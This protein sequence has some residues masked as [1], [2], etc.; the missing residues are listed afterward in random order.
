MLAP[1][2][3]PMWGIIDGMC[4]VLDGGLRRYLEEARA[5]LCEACELD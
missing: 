4:Q 3:I 1:G 2:V 5:V